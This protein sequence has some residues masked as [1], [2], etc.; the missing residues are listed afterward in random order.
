MAAERGAAEPSLVPDRE[1]FGAYTHEEIWEL[2]RET[3]D[4]AALGAAAESWRRHAELIDRAFRAFAA[5]TEAELAHWTG[6][7]ADQTRR[8]TRDFVARGLAAAAT[9]AALHRLMASNAEAAQSI[10]GALLPPP[11][12][13]RPLPD[14]AAEAVHGGR[15]RME[16]DLEAAAALADA[17]DVM[18]YVYNATLPASGDRVPRFAPAPE[19]GGGRR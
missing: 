12:P 16:H 8:V 11:A 7:V 6:P 1:V 19:S 18:T 15:R 2:V 4:P 13:Y 9:C 3:L 5:N 17:R 10:R 14:P